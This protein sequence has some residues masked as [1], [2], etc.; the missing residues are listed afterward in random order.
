MTAW[1]D[2][3]QEGNGEPLAIVLRPANA[4]ANT[5]ANLIEASHLALGQLPAPPAP[6]G[7]GPDRFRGGTYEF[8]GWL[9]AK[10]RRLYYSV[11]MVITESNR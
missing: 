10:S 3:G 5:A 6:Q 7:A 1:A 9:T 2:H 8:L 4:G 11:A